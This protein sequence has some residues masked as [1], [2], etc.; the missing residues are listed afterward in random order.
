MVL[1]SRQLSHQ[2]RQAIS[3]TGIWLDR[4]EQAKCWREIKLPS[5]RRLIRHVNRHLF[6]PCQRHYHLAPS[7]DLASSVAAWGDAPQ[8]DTKA[9]LTWLSHAEGGG[10]SASSLSPT[11]VQRSDRGARLAAAETALTQVL[12]LAPDQAWAHL[13]GRERLIDGVQQAGVREA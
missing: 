12:L 6:A 10:F 3:S 13:A 11:A 4:E 9:D 1:S 2:A 7:P 8:C 5:E